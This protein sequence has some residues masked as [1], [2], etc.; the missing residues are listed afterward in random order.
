VQRSLAVGSIDAGV[1]ID[2]AF[3]TNACSAASFVSQQ[4]LLWA[5]S[6]RVVSSALVP[7]DSLVLR[8]LWRSMLE[9]AAFMLKF[10]VDECVCALDQLDS[11]PCS[12]TVATRSTAVSRVSCS[13]MRITAHP[14]AVSTSSARRSRS[15]LRRSFGVQYQSLVV[16]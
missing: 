12:T 16:G 8:A 3:L 13:Q 14:A 9:Q 4:S 1:P 5:R 10:G 7:S 2:V 11:N 15:M 6:R